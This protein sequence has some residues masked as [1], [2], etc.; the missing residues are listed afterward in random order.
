MQKHF[1][2]HTFSLP[3]SSFSGSPGKFKQ[4]VV[5][6]L[7]NTPGGMPVCDINKK[8]REIKTFYW[9]CSIASSEKCINTM[10]FSLLLRQ[11]HYEDTEYI[12]RQGARGDTFFIISK[13]KVRTPPRAYHK[14]N[15]GDAE[16]RGPYGKRHLAAS[17]VSCSSIFWGGKQAAINH[18]EMGRETEAPPLSSSL[19]AAWGSVEEGGWSHFHFTFLPSA[20][21]FTPS[22]PAFMC[23]YSQHFLKSS[24]VRGMKVPL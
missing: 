19:T 8:K 18:L 24:H 22:R 10:L 6:R 3:A 11:T 4:I 21:A 23:Q 17:E 15:H 20:L 2:I 16:R 7:R 9:D 12:I 5:G 14:N 1:Y 13:G